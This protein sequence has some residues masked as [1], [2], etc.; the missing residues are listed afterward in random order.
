MQKQL[1]PARQSSLSNGKFRGKRHQITLAGVAALTLLVPLLVT[2]PNATPPA[3]ASSVSVLDNQVPKTLVDPDTISVELGSKFSSTQDGTISAIRFYKTNVNEGPHVANLWS[4]NGKTLATATLPESAATAD[5]WQTVT[6]PAPVKIAKNEKYIASY[7]APKGRY[8]A[9]EYGLAQSRTSGPLTLPAN[10]GVYAYGTGG[11][12]PTSTYKSSNYFVDVV[13]RPTATTDPATP[14]TSSPAPTATPPRPS[15]PTAT[16][17]SSPTPTAA[18]P[19]TRPTTPPTTQPTTPGTLP[20][21]LSLPRIPWEGGASYWK[22]FKH[23]NDAGWSD[24]SFFPIVAW[25]NGISSN[26]EAEYDKKVGINTYIGMDSNTPYSLFKDNDV[27][28]IGGK[29]NGTFTEASTN[30][31]GNFLDDEVDGRFTPEEG[32]KLLQSLKDKNAGNGRFNYSNFTQMVISNDM[33]ASDSQA[34]VN[35][36]TDAVSLDMYWY[37]IPFCSWSPFRQ[38]YITPVTQENCRTS[39]SYGKTMESLRKQD[40]ADGTLQAP[41][42]FIELLNGGPGGGPFTANVTAGQLK[43]SAMSSIIHEAR[44]LVYFNQSLS[45]PCQGGSLIRQSQVKPNFCGQA[46]VA[47]ATTVNN[48]IHTLAPVLN[49]QSYEYAFGPGL[50]TMLKAYNGSAY[51][52]SM[53]DGSSKPGSR[54]F[55]LPKD[56]KATS[57][58]VIDENRTI[59]VGADGT[60]TDNFASEFSYHIYKVG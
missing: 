4:A 41:W 7:T 51:V 18:G 14:P 10:G 42:Q 60:F 39:S 53:V 54:V 8:S 2:T 24:P 45:G 46:Q 38:N 44:G 48:Q 26:A 15:T 25:Y 49:T 19:T 55:T 9:E 13:F 11:E 57:V 43:G 28:W 33:K 52:F 32:R 30:W 31:V 20:A 1:P 21:T 34:Y 16:A 23:A 59:V 37:T 47:A 56:I 29:L 17:T 22:Q 40:A 58:Q 36:Y 35:N 3:F 6:F 12:M 5:G 50:D 27:Y